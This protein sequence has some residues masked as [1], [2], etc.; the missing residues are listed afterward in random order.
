MAVLEMIRRLQL[1]N[2][3]P[4]AKFVM[5]ASHAA[6]SHIRTF[7]QKFGDSLLDNSGRGDEALAAVRTLAEN[8]DHLTIN[9]PRMEVWK[10]VVDCAIDVGEEGT[11]ELAALEIAYD[12]GQEIRDILE[13][14]Q[15]E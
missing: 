6:D 14:R 11:L 13:R 2:E 1:P 7:L 4:L 3:D 10:A 9:S 5:L 15:K 12:A 8:I